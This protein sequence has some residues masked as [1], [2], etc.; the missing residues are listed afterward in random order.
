MEKI[1]QMIYDFNE[2]DLYEPWSSNNHL[3]IGNK[4]DKVMVLCIYQHD[5]QKDETNIHKFLV[6]R[7][8]DASIFTSQ[9]G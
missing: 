8:K 2:T 1:S 9:E 5:K 7:I 6:V 3:T 4:H